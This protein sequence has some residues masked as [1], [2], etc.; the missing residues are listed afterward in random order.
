MIATGLRPRCALGVVCALLLVAAACGGS[1]DDSS[2]EKARNRT[3]ATTHTTTATTQATTAA[4]GGPACTGA[5]APVRYDHVIVV[6]MENKS[7]GDVLKGQGQWLTARKNECFTATNFVQSASPSR[8]NYIALVAGATYG[9]EGSNADPPGGCTPPSPS[10]FKQV[11]DA[12]GTA[13]NYL[14]GAPSACGV[15][16]GGR[17]AVKHAPWPYFADEQR[18]VHRQRPGGRL[19]RLPRSRAPADARL[20]QPRPLRRH[21]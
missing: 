9:C 18:A 4:T 6:V 7:W 10:L 5:P 12:G 13:K 14:G 11:I 2:T 15:V 21:T 19:F 3:T 17:Y 16:S 20:R 1:G 8:P